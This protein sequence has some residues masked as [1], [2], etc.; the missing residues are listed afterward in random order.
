MGRLIDRVQTWGS[1]PVVNPRRGKLPGVDPVPDGPLQAL[2]LGLITI[3]VLAV[4]MA[5]TIAFGDSAG[6]FIYANF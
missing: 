6:G 5:V 4:A 3:V 2:A 1:V